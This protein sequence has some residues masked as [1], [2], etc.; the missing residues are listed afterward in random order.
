M[1]A[2][3]EIRPRSILRRAQSSASVLRDPRQDEQ[4]RANAE[5]ARH[6][7]LTAA[8][9]AFERSRYNSEDSNE[10][11]AGNAEKI[12][13]LRRRQSV[14]FTGPNAKSIHHRSITR[15][16]APTWEHVQ[17]GYQFRS[18]KLRRK[19]SA[20]GPPGNYVPFSTSQPHPRKAKSMLS[21]RLTTPSI[22]S[23]SGSRPHGLPNRSYRR[24]SGSTE[25]APGT[26]YRI[27][28]TAD[29]AFRLLPRPS[30]LTYNQDAAI[31]MARDEYIRQLEA[32]ELKRNNSNSSKRSRLRPQ[33]SFRR[34]VRSCSTN[35][36]GA[37]ITSRPDQETPKKKGFV[38][39]ARR[40]SGGL[41]ERLRRALHLKN[42]AK[43]LPIQQVDAERLHFGDQD[44]AKTDSNDNNPCYSIFD[45]T[46][47][48]SISS[49]TSS[50]N[51]HRVSSNPSIGSNGSDVTKSRVTSWT[52]STTTNATR[53]LL[54]SEVK[55][56]S[57]IQENG[58]PYQPSSS[59]GIVGTGS[60][61]GYEVFRRPIDHDSGRMNEPLDSH[62]VYSALQHRLDKTK[63]AI[64]RNGQDNKSVASS[65]GNESRSS[66][67][68][69]RK[70]SRG[71]QG[72]AHTTVRMVSNPSV[73]SLTV[74]IVDSK[75]SNKGSSSSKYSDDVFR[76]SPKDSS[77]LKV[78]APARKSSLTF[79]QM[80]N[81]N[82]ARTRSHFGPL[83]ESRSAFFPP[84]RH[85]HRANLSPYRSAMQLEDESD[86]NGAKNLT[87]PPF[88]NGQAKNGVHSASSSVYSQHSDGRPVTPKKG[89][90][91]V[92]P[93]E[94]AV[95][96]EKSILNPETGTREP[97]SDSTNLSAPQGLRKLLAREQSC[98]WQ[99]HL[100][101]FMASSDEHHYDI[102]SKTHP[103]FY[104]PNG[105]HRE[106]A[107]IHG[108]DTDVGGRGYSLSKAH[109]LAARGS[110][111][112]RARLRQ[113]SSGQRSGDHARR[114]PLAERSR[115][116]SSNIQHSTIV[117][118]DKGEGWR[119]KSDVENMKVSSSSATQ[120]GS[121]SYDFPQKSSSASNI[122]R[123]ESEHSVKLPNRSPIAP[124]ASSRLHRSSFRL[125]NRQSSPE[126]EARLRRIKSSIPVRTQTTS[127]P[128]NW[129]QPNGNTRHIR[130]SQGINS[131]TPT[132]S[133]D[134]LYSFGGGGI[135]GTPP[136]GAQSSS[137]RM[138]D[139]FL[140]SRKSMN[141]ISR[142]A[143]P[144]FI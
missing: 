38:F 39:Q 138:V 5:A 81:L 52:D 91:P 32:Q 102:M 37:A 71:T 130:E 80:A 103:I 51:R 1:P 65:E 109:A 59:A 122:S 92:R 118:I 67:D 79:Q 99:K 110:A 15:R 22:F 18:P 69:T 58:G 127:S 45:D 54:P 121:G 77:Q 44:F 10:N 83:V 60:G 49:R 11:T 35:S 101:A 25:V 137:T 2:N 16:R 104:R 78:L 6:H 43:S 72:T 3:R 124:K 50:L 93:A 75:S 4:E 23:R 119:K 74:S 24:L 40:V 47:M 115:S 140:S 12:K 8:A 129:S 107:Q 100:S 89:D 33:R 113:L 132:L 56:L 9:L 142:T 105:H 55:R 116:S 19:D 120:V 64:G 66:R 108:D 123:P 14:R 95:S 13:E 53:R 17:T 82:D 21:L 94:A 125:N 7:A 90:A 106:N 96:E 85:L 68:T 41:K 30:S 29:E 57:I 20:L 136:R 46:L 131:S 98:E 112:L 117:P 48:S 42:S 141:D 63:Q 88:N 143:S 73:E 31:Q 84:Q 139:L 133:F 134:S 34:T 128:E 87:G 61:R 70:P 76:P 144:V 26:P 111:R 36:Y 62:L 114:P 135:T 28:K 97:S 27:P 126:R 86:F